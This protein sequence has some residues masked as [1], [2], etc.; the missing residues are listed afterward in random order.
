MPGVKGGASEFSADGTFVGAVQQEHRI[1]PLISVE[2]AG[3]DERFDHR[4]GN[5]ALVEQ[6][7]FDPQEVGR[8]RRRELEPWGRGARDLRRLPGS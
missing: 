7:A 8:L 1:A 6:I 2:P 3:L 4:G 5:V